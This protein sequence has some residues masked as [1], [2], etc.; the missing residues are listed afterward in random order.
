MTNQERNK[1]QERVAKER[2][3]TGKSLRW[4]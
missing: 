1:R 4:N 2:N 3:R